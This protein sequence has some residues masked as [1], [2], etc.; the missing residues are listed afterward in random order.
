MRLGRTA[1]TLGALAVVAAVFA[2]GDSDSSKSG[3]PGT[4][5]A[6]GGGVCCPMEN[7]CGPGY[8]GGW[9][10]SAGDCGPVNSHDGR[11]DELVD[12]HGCKYW[13]SSFAT[14]S[15]CCG[16]LATKPDAAADASSPD[17]SSPDA[18]SSDAESDA[19]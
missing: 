16:C 3:P 18:S 6:A 11:F 4:T 17:A 13:S 5:P 15:Y 2:C 1:V 7:P 8:R 12:D 9:A 10:P 19:D 14:G